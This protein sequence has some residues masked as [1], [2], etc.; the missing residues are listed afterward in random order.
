MSGRLQALVADASGCRLPAE[1]GAA[2]G[3]VPVDDQRPVGTAGHP[4]QVTG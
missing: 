2:P 1:P 3:S 4:H